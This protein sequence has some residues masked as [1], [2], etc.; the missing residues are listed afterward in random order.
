MPHCDRVNRTGAFCR[1]NLMHPLRSWFTSGQ[2]LG[3]KG[4]QLWQRR[5]G[6]HFSSEQFHWRVICQEFQLLQTPAECVSQKC[7]LRLLNHHQP[8]AE[9]Q[10]APAK[11]V[12][13]VSAGNYCQST[14]FLI[15]RRA[16]CVAVL[17][18]LRFL[19][20]KRSMI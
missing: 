2:V 9:T 6:S 3:E 17:F 1:S 15:C 18:F 4:P 19:Q 7:E 10:W 16:G 13:L 14:G 11:L 20:C 12:D 5:R 8:S